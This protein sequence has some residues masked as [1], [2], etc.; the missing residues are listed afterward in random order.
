MALLGSSCAQSMPGMAAM[1]KDY[2]FPHCWNTTQ[3]YDIDFVGPVKNETIG[4]PAP[5]RTLCNGGA[6]CLGN[7]L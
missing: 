3:A 5:R 2:P 1:P 6:E 4:E 7:R